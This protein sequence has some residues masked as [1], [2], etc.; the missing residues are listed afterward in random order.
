MSTASSNNN[1]TYWIF[2]FNQSLESH[3]CIHSVKTVHMQAI[4]PILDTAKSCLQTLLLAAV[5]VD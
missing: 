1:S 2:F 4:N 3:S 5:T